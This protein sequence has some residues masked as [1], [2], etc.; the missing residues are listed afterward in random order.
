ME[1][2]N[3]LYLREADRGQL[4]GDGPVDVWMRHGLKCKPPKVAYAREFASG[5]VVCMACPHGP[6]QAPGGIGRGREMVIHKE[7]K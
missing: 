4:K 3:D 7:S 6:C 5:R 1:I 2:R